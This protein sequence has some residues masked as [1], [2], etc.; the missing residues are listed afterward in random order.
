ML[1]NIQLVRLRAGETHWKFIAHGATYTRADADEIKR[2][3]ESRGDKIRF[4]FTR[5]VRK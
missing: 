1:K 2:D 3:Y 4:L 5:K